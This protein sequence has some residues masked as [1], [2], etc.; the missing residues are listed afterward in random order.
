MDLIDQF[1]LCLVH[2]APNRGCTLGSAHGDT[3]NQ[4]ACRVGRRW[5]GRRARGQSGVTNQ[6]QPKRPLKDCHNMREGIMV[7]L[8]LMGKRS[9]N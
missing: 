5:A 1:P 8:V 6:S 3:Q 2:L 9:S 7:L 4:S